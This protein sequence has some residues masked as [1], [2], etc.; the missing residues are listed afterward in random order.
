MD[1][2]ETQWGGEDWP[3]LAQDRY[4]WRAL[5]NTVLKFQLPQN[6]GKLLSGYKTDG[7][8]SST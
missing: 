1:L 4:K 7:L 8:S 5:V 3:G 6:S 2:V